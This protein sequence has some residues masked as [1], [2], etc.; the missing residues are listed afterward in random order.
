MRRQ[1]HRGVGSP[2]RRTTLTLPADALSDAERIARSRNVTLST[3]IAEA[4]TDGLQL[5]AA[6]KRGEQVLR[7]YEQAFAGFSE[8]ELMVLDGIVLDPLPAK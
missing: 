7:A 1:L 8:E 6:A 5:R 3:V 2:K 4:L